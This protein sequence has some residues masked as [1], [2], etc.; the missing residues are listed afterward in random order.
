MKIENLWPDFGEFANYNTPKEILEQQAK[1]LPKLTGEIIYAEIRDLTDGDIMFDQEISG[2]DF[3]YKFLLK[4]KFM[5]KYQFEIM[6]IFHDISI[7]P[8]NIRIEKLI[9]EEVTPDKPQRSLKIASEEEFNKLLFDIFHSSRM[10]NV[11]GSL[12]KLSK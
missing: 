7:Y 11:I 9:K 8:I 1:F 6:T 12:F 2:A 3:S 4:S 5:D 10:K